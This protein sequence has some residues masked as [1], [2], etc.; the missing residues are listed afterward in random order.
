MNFKYYGCWKF[1]KFNAFSWLLI[2]LFVQTVHAAGTLDWNAT[3]PIWPAGAFNNN[4]VNIGTPPVNITG[5][6][7]GNTDDLNDCN[8]NTITTPSTI[9]FGG[10][11]TFCADYELSLIHI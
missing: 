3:A 8:T 4:Y 2:L 9:F 7:V 11:L 10:E 6:V 1:L 5:T